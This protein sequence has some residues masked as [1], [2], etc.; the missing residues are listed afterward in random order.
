MMSWGPEDAFF[1]MSEYG[2][3]AY[4]LGDKT[5]DDWSIWKETVEDWKSEKG[6]RWSEC[7]VSVLSFYSSARVSKNMVMLK[8]HDFLY[9]GVG[10]F[11]QIEGLRR[12]TGQANM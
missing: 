8:F 9:L 2:D 1:A 3:V 7:A 4:R 11:I 10:N 6:F 5:R 12:E